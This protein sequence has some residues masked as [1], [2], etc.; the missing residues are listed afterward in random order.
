[1]HAEEL[2]G[3]TDS[4]DR[5]KRQRWFQ[6]AFLRGEVPRVQ[7]VDVLS[8]T[9]TM[10]A[11]VDIGALF[12]I[13]LANMPPR[14]FNYQQRVGRAGRRSGAVALSVTFCRGRS[15]DDFYFQRPESITGDPPPSPYVDMRS[16][17]IL[18]R[19][20][21][22]EVMRL[23][24]SQLGL[25][26]GTSGDSVHGE[27]GSASDWE[28]YRQAIGTWLTTER[29]QKVIGN[30]LGTLCVASRISQDERNEIAGS[31]ASDLVRRIDAIVADPSYNQVNLSERLAN[32]GLL[33]MFGFPTRVRVLYTRFPQ[34]SP[35]PPRYGVI[36]RDVDVALSQFAPG[37]Q[38][39]KDKA[40]HTACGLVDFGPSGSG[41]A[42][43]RPGLVPSLKYPNPAP[44]GLCT[45][46]Q[47]LVTLAHSL[48]P[49]PATTLVN[50]VA[51]PVCGSET[52]RELDAREP[53]GFFSNFEPQEF[54]GRFEWTP[55]A[56]RPTLA[57]GNSGFENSIV[58]NASVSS[59]TD[60]ILTI[61][62]NGNQGGFA[63]RTATFF[64]KPRFGAY[65]VEGFVGNNVGVSGDAIRAALVSRRRTDVL[66]ADIDKWPR[67]V[68]ADP[69]TV[70]GRAAWYSFAFLLRI[71]AGAH[72][73]V[74][75]LEL[76]ASFRTTTGLKGP[77]GQAFLSDRLENGA[78]YSRFLSLPEQFDCLLQA[79][80]RVDGVIRAKWAAR[81]HSSR[82]DT[83]CNLCLRD[84]ASAMFHSLLDWRLALDMAMIAA[85]SNSDISL[86]RAAGTPGIWDDLVSPAGQ[87][88]SLLSQLGYMPPETFGKLRGFKHTLPDWNILLL[89]RHPLWT[90]DHPSW[91][92]AS[93]LA[94]ERHP[95]VDIKPVDPFLL[96]RRPGDFLGL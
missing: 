47:A 52:M 84:Y 35:W 49:Q 77:K 41:D 3:Q 24:F 92:E 67:G 25:E 50:I 58:G 9:T 70:V 61:N 2:T 65:A 46:C 6:D 82:C 31:L 45:N 43:I 56:G 83:S 33:P 81:Q 78:G 4:A 74:D 42:D 75:P 21:I 87:A 55:R 90:N 66:L 63:F 85:D 73:D 89:E 95:R 93:K 96:V 23:A 88:Q 20:A 44:I 60:D 91:I 39:V 17:P 34:G 38:V 79:G 28:K 80:T 71:A 69:T 30:I 94:A 13:V 57:V 36:D 59:F 40:V 10:E 37:S 48:D 27:F 19:V 76:D 1:M 51:C 86:I 54:E 32:A 8:V 12:A 18:E 53:Q 29:A 11:G 22:K 7:G 26:P 16:V 62:E 14:R 72:L 15:H 5:Q 64:G 68:L